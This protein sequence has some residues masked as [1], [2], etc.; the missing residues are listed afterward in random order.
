[1]SLTKRALFDQLEANTPE[2]IIA[3]VNRHLA[4]ALRSA[5]DCESPDFETLDAIARAILSARDEMD[6]LTASLAALEL[7]AF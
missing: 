3:T 6:H 7:A 4:L 5:C 2:T 1:M